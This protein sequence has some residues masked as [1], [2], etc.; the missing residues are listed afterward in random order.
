MEGRYPIDRGMRILG[1]FVL[2]MLGLNIFELAAISRIVAIIVGSYGFLTGIINFCPILMGINKEKEMKRKKTQSKQA[3]PLT[4]LKGLRFFSGFSDEEIEKIFQSCKLK[5]Y[6]PST[7]IIKEGKQTRKSLYIIFSG[8]C[9][10]LKTLSEMGS[11][12]IKTI[13]DG[14]VF[15][16]LSDNPPCFSFMSIDT[17]KVLEIEEEPFRLL[18]QQ[19]PRLTNKI[20]EKLLPVMSMYMCALNEQVNY[21]GNWVLQGRVQSPT[22]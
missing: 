19:S 8:Q 6:P 15:G 21:L 17:A 20:Y 3:V 1:G 5:E 4:A 13:S 12:I 18:L 10:V 7:N 2:I 9:R 11:K 22:L 14:E 16:E